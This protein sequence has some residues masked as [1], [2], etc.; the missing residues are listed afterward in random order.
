[1]LSSLFKRQYSIYLSVDISVNDLKSKI[2]CDYFSIDSERIYKEALAANTLTESGSCEEQVI[3]YIK[4]K[5]TDML[6]CSAVDDSHSLQRIEK[7]ISKYGFKINKVF[8]LSKSSMAIQ[9]HSDYGN[10]SRWMDVDPRNIGS[11]VDERCK[12]HADLELVAKEL[13]I[14]LVKI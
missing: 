9:Y 6:V 4:S 11:L 2:D 12:K 1:M 7:R 3:E 10:F 14:E 8:V 13:K 5:K